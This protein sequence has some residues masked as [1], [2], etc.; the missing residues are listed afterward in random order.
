VKR[1]AWGLR[2]CGRAHIRLSRLHL[3]PTIL[4]PLIWLLPGAKVK[5]SKQKP[6]ENVSTVW[7]VKIA[8]LEGS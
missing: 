5:I 7:G 6:I 2:M 8:F 1:L 4:V 3:R